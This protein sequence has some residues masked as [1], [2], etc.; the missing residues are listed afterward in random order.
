MSY[1]LFLQHLREMC[2]GVFDNLFLW[3]TSLAEAIPTFL[4]LS[5]IYWCAD[6]EMGIYMAGNVGLSCTFSQYFKWLFRID[7]PWAQ[8]P[9][10]VPVQAAL[11]KAGGTLFPADIQCVLPQPGGLWEHTPAGGINIYGILAG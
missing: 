4:L 10:I 9:R 5:F 11:S 1:L 2:G 3:I 7:R 8:D 6:K